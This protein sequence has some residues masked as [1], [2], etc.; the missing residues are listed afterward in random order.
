MPER[1]IADLHTSII[2]RM[3][4]QLSTSEAG[5]EMTVL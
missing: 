3:K 1:R 4:A 2:R 5:E